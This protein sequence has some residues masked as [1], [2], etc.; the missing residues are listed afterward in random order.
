M[1]TN[2]YLEGILA[3]SY[4]H[5]VDQE[6]LLARS[7]PSLATALAVLAILLAVALPE[8]PMLAW[9]PYSIVVYLILAFLAISAFLAILFLV[10]A[11]WPRRFAYLMRE[12]D[13]SSYMRN[14]RRY[15]RHTELS[16][17]E[18]EE[19]VAADVRD[20]MIEQYAEGAIRNRANNAERAG[21]RSGALAALLAALAFAFLMMAALLIHDGLKGHRDVGAAQRGYRS[22]ASQELGPRQADGADLLQAGTTAHA[23]GAERRLGA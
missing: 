14:L 10:W 13:L 17:A 22:V 5:E 2:E 15:Y 21:A 18:I 23:A 1:E 11:L 3:D 19:A 8:I 4:R 9:S 7:L 20:A 6:E 16:P 12:S